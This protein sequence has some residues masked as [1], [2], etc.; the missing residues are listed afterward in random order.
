[1][2]TNL[3]GLR[4][5]RFATLTSQ[6]SSTPIPKLPPLQNQR[7]IMSAN[8]PNTNINRSM[9]VR[10]SNQ[11]HVLLLFVHRYLLQGLFHLKCIGSVFTFKIVLG[12]FNLLWGEEDKVLCFV[13]FYVRF[14]T[15]FFRWPG[16]I[17]SFVQ[18]SFKMHFH[19]VVCQYFALGSFI[20]Q[21]LSK[22]NVIGH[23][24]LGLLA[25]VH[26]DDQS[27]L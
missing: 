7:A 18:N 24:W 5:H 15:G 12:V 10:R 25:L 1:M 20:D 23:K 3:D 19:L 2:N 21:G 16:I 17:D 11:M 9:Q 14:F 4:G 13:N 8:V 6:P 27:Q 26:Q 22:T